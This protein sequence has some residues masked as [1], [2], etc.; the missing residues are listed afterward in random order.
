M[1]RLT[2][3]V[4]EAFFQFSWSLLGESMHRHLGWLQVLMMQPLPGGLEDGPQVCWATADASVRSKLVFC[5]NPPGT[6]LWVSS[7]PCEYQAA[8]GFFFLYRKSASFF[9]DT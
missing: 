4:G 2:L 8:L 6:W 5:S 3:G 7:E 9:Q 1:E